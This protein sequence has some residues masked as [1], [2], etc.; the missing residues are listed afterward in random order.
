MNKRKFEIPSVK[1]VNFVSKDIITT[2]GETDPTTPNPGD[3]TGGESD[4]DRVKSIV[5][6]KTGKVSWD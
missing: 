5:G 4:P 2:S 1:V 3:W 6:F